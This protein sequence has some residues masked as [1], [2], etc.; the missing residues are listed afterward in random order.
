LPDIEQRF[1]QRYG[2]RG[3]TVVALNA[4]DAL[5]QI[6]EVRRFVDKLGI[7]Y[8][9]GLEQTETYRAITENFA[10]TNPFPVDVV[11]DRDG[12]IAYIAREYDPDAM[13]RVI[14]RLLAR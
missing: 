2:R 9:A 6:D 3:L 10:G 4:H 13:A 12:R 11:V 8:P 5:E 14:E 7:S 1:L